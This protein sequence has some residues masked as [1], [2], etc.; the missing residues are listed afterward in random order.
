MF[1]FS[2]SSSSTCLSNPSYPSLFCFLALICIS[3]LKICR[4][5]F[6]RASSEP[7]LSLYISFNSPKNPQKRHYQSHCPDGKAEIFFAQGHR[8][9]ELGL[10][11]K[12]RS[13]DSIIHN[14]LFPSTPGCFISVSFFHDV[15]KR[16][17]QMLAIQKPI[18]K[19]L[20]WWKRK[21]AL[22]Q[23]LATGGEGGL[24]SKGYLLPDNQWARA[25]I[26]LFIYLFIIFIFFLIL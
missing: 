14:Q 25:G 18:L 10:K 19:R 4:S 15:S 3:H 2:S 12:S 21:S 16:G 17:I 7:E 5:H 11:F 13:P 6:L 23:R 8:S 24:V 22:F 20:G 1:R 9:R 26:Y